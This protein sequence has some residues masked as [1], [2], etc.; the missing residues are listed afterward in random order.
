[1]GRYVVITDNLEGFDLGD[2]VRDGERPPGTLA[3]WL[4]TGHI[5]PVPP[6]SS[7]ED[8]ERFRAEVIDGPGV[9]D[10]EAMTVKELRAL[11]RENGLEGYARAHKGDLVRA[12]KEWV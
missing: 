3:R 12:L 4:T 8:I 10:L 1:M 9:D 6:R 11:A 7:E 5:T 2:I